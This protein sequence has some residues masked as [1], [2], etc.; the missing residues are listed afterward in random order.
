[1]SISL[2]ISSSEA[3]FILNNPNQI[4]SNNSNNNSN[5]NSARMEL[6][7]AIREM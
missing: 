4:I 7:N 3:E 2:N 5:N 6:M 1:M